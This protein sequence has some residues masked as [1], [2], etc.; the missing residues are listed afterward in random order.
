MNGWASAAEAR[1]AC[2]AQALTDAEPD[3]CRHAVCG[4]LPLSQAIAARAAA[5]RE[6]VAQMHRTGRSRGAATEPDLTARQPSSA[7][8]EREYEM[9][10]PDGTAAEQP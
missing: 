2:C 9:V 4:E 10:R 6:Q 8:T 7:L 3:G 1:G 5:N